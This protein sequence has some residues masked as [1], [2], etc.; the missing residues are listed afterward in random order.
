[1]VDSSLP[2][3]IC[4]KII[5]RKTDGKKD[6]SGN[7]MLKL[8]SKTANLR[9]I[10]YD[11]L[12]PIL[13]RLLLCRENKIDSRSCPYPDYDNHMA[14]KK[15]C[16]LEEKLAHIYF[17]YEQPKKVD[18]NTPSCIVIF[19]RSNIQHTDE[20]AQRL[21]NTV[22]L[23][24]INEKIVFHVIN[25]SFEKITV[26]SLNRHKLKKII[27]NCW[28]GSRLKVGKNIEMNKKNNRMVLE[29]NH[30]SETA[31]F[32]IKPGIEVSK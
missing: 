10:R 25:F 3:T 12:E 16:Q 32:S 22:T 5:V 1:L 9:W 14:V 17:R 21:K 7:L 13:F 2:D 27:K 18:T 11:V 20:I 4:P 24:S 28:P 26:H 19:V 23:L 15:I 6:N 29:I 31:E 8:S 30:I